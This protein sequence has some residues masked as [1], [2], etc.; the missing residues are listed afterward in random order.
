MYVILLDRLER[1]VL[2]E[3]NRAVVF[4]AAGAKVDEPRTFEEAQSA[5]DEALAADPRDMNPH[6]QLLKQLGVAA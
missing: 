3:A 6:R 1:R 5:F 2:A 4:A